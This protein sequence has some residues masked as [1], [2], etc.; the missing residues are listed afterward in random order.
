[1]MKSG[2]WGI[3]LILLI[4]V[5]RVAVTSGLAG[6]LKPIWLSLICTN[7]KSALLAALRLALL[8]N[9]RDAGMPPLMVQTRPVPAHAMHFRNPRRSTPSLL[10]SCNFQAW[11]N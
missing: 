11:R 8:A 7:V 10:R 9:A 3:A 2:F 4:A 6:L 1:M 5:C